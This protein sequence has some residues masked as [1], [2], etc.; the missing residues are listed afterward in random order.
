MPAVHERER[1]VT[2]LARPRR[3]IV[4]PRR[5][6]HDPGRQ[7]RGDVRGFEDERARGAAGV[8]RGDDVERR[9]R[10]SRVGVHGRARLDRHR[11]V[12]DEVRVHPRERERRPHVVPAA[13]QRAV[14]AR[15]PPRRDRERDR[16]LAEVSRSEPGVLRRRHLEGLVPPLA[17]RSEADRDDRARRHP[18]ARLPHRAVRLDFHDR[19]VGAGDVRAL[20]RGY[21][22]LQRAARD[23]FPRRRRRGAA[24]RRRHRRRAH[25]RGRADA[26][27]D[28]A[29]DA[30]TA[31][32]ALLRHEEVLLIRGEDL[33]PGGQ[34]HGRR[35][36]AAADR[37]VAAAAVR[38]ARLL[39]RGGDDRGG[40]RVHDLREVA[41]PEAPVPAR[42]VK[43][44]RCRPRHDG[45][46]R[47]R[48]R[49]DPHRSP[50]AVPALVRDV[51]HDPALA[52]HG[53]HLRDIVHDGDVLARGLVPVARAPLALGDEVPNLR[54]RVRL[55]EGVMVPVRRP[56]D[57]MERRELARGDRQRALERHALAALNRHLHALRWD[58]R[59]GGRRRRRLDGRRGVPSVRAS[60]AKRRTTTTTDA[61][62]DERGSARSRAPS[63]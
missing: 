52:E 19:D 50:R 34:R 1:G 33:L 14:R 58:E 57:V 35:R 55:Q 42:D 13:D 18:V 32:A 20:I 5:S 59:E 27:S 61:R 46:E 45:A 8:L 51:D 31:V 29:S 43:R 16:S 28:A 38:A 37:S 11:N 9:P 62:S 10:R 21:R 30:A 48:R 6:E 56:L 23:E 44:A 53:L 54:L 40:D 39:V 26:A 47:L 7:R 2:R 36:R 15:G 17:V 25:H 12:H 60:E 22:R 3:L 24:S 63:P 49:P 4:R 41:P